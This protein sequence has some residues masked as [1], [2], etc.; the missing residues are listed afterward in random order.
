MKKWESPFKYE[1]DQQVQYVCD[2][3][4]MHTGTVRERWWN[5]M[6]YDNVYRVQFENR[7]RMLREDQ[8]V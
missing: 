4:C 7:E 2:A 6:V 5:G 8:L 3:G 1:V